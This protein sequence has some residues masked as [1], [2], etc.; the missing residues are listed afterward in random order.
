MTNYENDLAVA[1]TANTEKRDTIVHFTNRNQVEQAMQKQ[2]QNQKMKKKSQFKNGQ[3][4][5]TEYT[6]NGIF[7][8][9]DKK[10]KMRDIT[11]SSKVN[12]AVKVYGMKNTIST[13]ESKTLD[14]DLKIKKPRFIET[15]PF[16]ATL[17]T[18]K[19]YGYKGLQ[20]DQGAS[21]I[22]KT[23]N[24]MSPDFRSH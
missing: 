16:D 11:K 10:V 6:L 19:P 23:I 4:V 3:R 14:D 18:M 20:D 5:A 17:S 21:D 8:T 7:E 22:V 13:L 24:I 9:A 1:S 2:I 12:Q 15:Q